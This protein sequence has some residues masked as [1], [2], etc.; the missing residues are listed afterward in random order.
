M[1][2]AAPRCQ[3]AGMGEGRRGDLRGL[4][5]ALGSVDWGHHEI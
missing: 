4:L 2:G 1:Q 3:L 5:M